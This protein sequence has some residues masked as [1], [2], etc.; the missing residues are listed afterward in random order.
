MV[1]IWNYQILALPHMDLLFFPSLILSSLS[2]SCMDKANC[3]FSALSCNIAFMSTNSSAHIFVLNFLFT[4]AYTGNDDD[5]NATTLSW[6]D[7]GNCS[8]A[9]V[10]ASSP[11]AVGHGAL[12]VSADCGSL[13]CACPAG[14][15]RGTWTQP[16]AVS[17]LPHAIGT[18]SPNV[19]VELLPLAEGTCP[20]A[21]LLFPL[22]AG[23]WPL[24][25]VAVA[26]L[27]L[28]TGPCPSVMRLL[29]L[30]PLVTGTWPVSAV[31]ALP[32]PLSAGT[33]PPVVVDMAS[34]TKPCNIWCISFNNFSLSSIRFS[35]CRSHFSRVPAR[36]ATKILHPHA[37]FKISRLNIS[38][39]RCRRPSHRRLLPR[40]TC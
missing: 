32:L 9:P 37:L 22:A 23:T 10:L 26:L 24:A 12:L 25:I 7:V 31:V 5:A 15:D 6:V 4:C 33:C 3:R 28:Y 18:C 17:P 35:I 11:S 14:I 36:S 40:S 38:L 2:P 30:L 19:A 29:L 16:C 21:I 13:L 39:C 1:I 34:P 8:N 27:P 20:P